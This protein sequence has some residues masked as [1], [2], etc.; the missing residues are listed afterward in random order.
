MKTFQLTGKISNL[1][2]RTNFLDRKYDENAGKPDK[3]LSI[4]LASWWSEPKNLFRDCA[5][6]QGNGR[7]VTEWLS[8]LEITLAQQMTW[9]S[10]IM[11]NTEITP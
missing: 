7:A 4:S 9:T 1:T 8:P 5:P 11:A 6:V 10:F 2:L 3:S